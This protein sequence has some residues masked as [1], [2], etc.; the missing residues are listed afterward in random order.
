VSLTIFEKADSREQTVGPDG[1]DVT[2]RYGVV[3]SEDDE[4]VRQAV[5]AE[6]PAYFNRLPIQ[7]YQLSPQ[8]GGC[9]EVEVKYAQ[10]HHDGADSPTGDGQ[11]DGTGG[12]G[13]DAS[14]QG[15]GKPQSWEF[16]F[17][18]SGGTHKLFQSY[19]TRSY[20]TSELDRVDLGGQIGVEGDKAEGVEV[21][22]PAFAFSLKTSVKPPLNTAWLQALYR[23]TGAINS[24]RVV[25]N[26]RGTPLVFEAGE[27]LCQGASGSVNQEGD[28]D[29][30]LKLAA[31][32]NDSTLVIGTITGIVKRGWEY[33]WVRSEVKTVSNVLVPDPIEVYVERVHPELDFN[34]VI[35]P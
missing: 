4:L 34:T 2:L 16:S 3:G 33:L 21:Q 10:K 26:V 8:G 23:I 11:T 6:I 27:L 24:S 14:K 13:G 22:I 35:N 32:Q 25:I 17:D 18:T 9:W 1:P 5:E 29:L 28:W 31:S 7:N 12:D 30:T 19:A 15:D 20:V